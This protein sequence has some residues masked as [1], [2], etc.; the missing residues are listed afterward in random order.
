MEKNKEWLSGAITCCPFCDEEMHHVTATPES[1]A[2][3]FCPE[4]MDYGYDPE[5]MLPI[6]VFRGT[7]EHMD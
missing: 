2:F 7:V 5:T 6:V 4:C 1:P 3:L